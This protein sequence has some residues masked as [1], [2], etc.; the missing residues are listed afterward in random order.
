MQEKI[1]AVYI[2]ANQ[3]NGTLY[4]GVTSNLERRVWQHKNGYFKAGFTSKYGVKM[5]V[6]YELHG[7]IQMALKREKNIQ[8]W[9]RLWK[10]RL[11]ESMNP[12]WHDLYFEL[13]GC[14]PTLA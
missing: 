8:A 12:E 11:I 1:Y 13:T 10:I 5:L 14:Q 2:M 7:N 4:T 6:Y 9:K 3:K